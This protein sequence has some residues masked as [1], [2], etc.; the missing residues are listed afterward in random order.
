[1]VCIAA[2]DLLLLNLL[3]LN[4]L[5]CPLQHTE[6]QR[7][8]LGSIRKS[9]RL[10]A[11]GDY[12]NIRA[13]ADAALSLLSSTESS[14]GPANLTKFDLRDA[15]ARVIELASKNGKEESDKEKEEVKVNH[16]GPDSLPP[17]VRAKAARWYRLQ[18][19]QRQEWLGV[20][21]CC[22]PAEPLRQKMLKVRRKRKAQVQRERMRGQM[23]EGWNTDGRDAG[24]GSGMRRGMAENDGGEGDGENYLGERGGEKMWES[25]SSFLS[26]SP[27]ASSPAVNST[28]TEAAQSQ[29]EKG[30][31]MTQMQQRET[32]RSAKLGQLKPRD[33]PLEVD[34]QEVVLR[35]STPGQSHVQQANS[36]ACAAAFLLAL[37]TMAPQHF[38]FVAQTALKRWMYGTVTSSAPPPFSQGVKN[39]TQMMLHVL[40]WSIAFA[41]QRMKDPAP[42][43]PESRISARR[44]VEEEEKRK[45]MNSER[46][47]E[48]PS[49]STGS[50]SSAMA[51]VHPHIS[52]PLTSQQQRTDSDSSLSRSLVTQMPRVPVAVTSKPR[53]GRGFSSS[54]AEARAA[55]EAMALVESRAEA[56]KTSQQD[57]TPS[58]PHHLSISTPLSSSQ[59]TNPLASS[60]TLSIPS[61]VSLSYLSEVSAPRS[62]PS[63]SSSFWA[64]GSAQPTIMSGGDTTMISTEPQDD[65]KGDA[66]QPGALGST[67]APPHS[68]VTTTP[69]APVVVA[70]EGT[71]V[72]GV[73]SLTVF[74]LRRS[75]PPSSTTAASSI[76]PDAAPSSSSPHISSSIS[77]TAASTLTHGR[78]VSPST[79]GSTASG[80]L[81]S[82]GGMGGDVEMSSSPAT[83]T[84]SPPV[85]SSSVVMTTT[86]SSS[87]PA[88]PTR[89]PGP[90]PRH[91]EGRTGPSFPSSERGS[92]RGREVMRI[93]SV[94]D[95]VS[96][97]L[98]PSASV[99]SSTEEPGNAAPHDRVSPSPRVVPPPMKLTTQ[100]LVAVSRSFADRQDEKEQEEETVDHGEGERKEEEG[101]EKE[102][103]TGEESSS[104]KTLAPDATAIGDQSGGTGDVEMESGKVRGT[105]EEGRQ[106]AASGS[107]GKLPA[108]TGEV[109]ESGS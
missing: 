67:P 82:T 22:S 52:L 81:S 44:L 8:L 64:S 17:A 16:S 87:I 49:S 84:S 76:N 54:E 29:G 48:G 108:L 65:N 34:G 9:I 18:A 47:G 92:G 91:L 24:L 40:T 59:L 60:T 70:G 4:S 36:T 20:A 53:R 21:A 89:P 62:S 33:V 55:R 2:C 77:V 57:L 37:S 3:F 74:S 66:S 38:V 50:L 90:I 45:A 51:S 97:P 43:F 69:S 101:E 78:G 109:S 14:E 83:T 72:D 25:Q 10:L 1:M 39:Q 6:S 80:S 13:V 12:T 63:P 99:A 94:A 30:G 79:S 5:S 106:E 27:D 35:T 93:S 107:G 28:L 23:R 98:G 32:K 41:P 96:R 95:D 85:P 88:P 7:Q 73:K 68:M 31:A 103:I 19:L 58:H 105:G 71:E 61:S 86:T 11:L 46:R 102:G 56:T 15:M 26:P 42:L 104:S 75:D 100:M